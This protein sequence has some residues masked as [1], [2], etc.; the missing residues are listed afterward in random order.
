MVITL[1]MAKGGVWKSTVAMNIAGV[2]A[3]R[4]KSVCIVDSDTPRETCNNNVRRRNEYNERQRAKGKQTVPEIHCQ[5]KRPEDRLNKHLEKLDEDFDYVLV[6]TGGYE[7]N[8]FKSAVAVSDL[9]YLPF[10]PCTDDMDN[11]VPTLNVIIETEGFIRNAYPDQYIDARLIV[12]GSD[13][14]SNDL[15]V[16]ALEFSRDLLPYTSISSAVIQRTK[17][18]VTL[19]DNGLT[20]ADVKHPKRSMFELLVDEINGDRDVKYKREIDLEE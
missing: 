15:L 6:D 4:G 5:I 14:N 3:N 2:L 20:L 8:A 1:G 7:N 17:K 10:F 13:H 18:V 9:I 16:E 12:T 19:K 11:L